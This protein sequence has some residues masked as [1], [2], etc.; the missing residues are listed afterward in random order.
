MSANPKNKNQRSKRPNTQPNRQVSTKLGSHLDLNDVDIMEQNKRLQSVILVDT[1]GSMTEYQ[2]LLKECVIRLYDEILSD[3]MA[4][5]SVELGVITFN[6]KTDVIQ[7][8]VEVYRQKD[9]GRNLSFKCDGATLTGHAVNV[10]LQKLDERR[11]KVK[12][13]GIQQYPPIL[14]ILSDGDPACPDDDKKEEKT[15]E[16]LKSNINRIRKRVA[17]QQLTV[18]CLQI[19]SAFNTNVM[20]QLTG[21]DTMEHVCKIDNNTTEIENFFKWASDYLKSKSKD[22]P[23]AKE[24]PEWK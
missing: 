11:N 23:P 5:H 8:I 2:S 12:M 20:Q 7:D 1:S 13:R 16:L 21:L 18:F 19:G 17:N 3:T 6:E 9:K 24:R 14:F 10:A 4:A 22:N 15:L